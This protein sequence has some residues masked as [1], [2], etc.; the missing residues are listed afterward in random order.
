MILA[1]GGLP[2]STMRAIV[3]DLV[4]PPVP[5]EVKD[6]DGAIDVTVSD[7][8]QG[9]PLAGATVRAFA[10]IGGKAY[11][12]AGARH[13]PRRPRAPDRASSRRG[14]AAGRRTRPRPGHRRGWSS[15]PG[16]AR[17][18]SS[19]SPEHLLD[20]VVRDEQGAAVDAAEI[21]VSDAGDSLPVGGRSD[22]DGAA[23]VGRLAAG[24]WR[25]TARAP[26]YE[27]ASARASRD[28]EQ[29]KLVLRKLGGLEITVRDEQDRPVAGAARRR[30]GR[31]AVATTLGA[32]R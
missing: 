22:R 19:L 6:R 24:P 3:H 31:D 21:E 18:A 16:C 7:G 1:L 28:G 5:A 27:D 14:L 26:G 12:A 32:D 20:V 15:R 4:A 30:G 11:L 17:C 8:P 29:V 25:L 9:P 10:L 23:H 2:G 13:R